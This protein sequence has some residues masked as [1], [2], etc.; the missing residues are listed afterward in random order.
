MKSRNTREA[1]ETTEQR[2]DRIA[3]RSACSLKKRDVRDATESEEQRVNRRAVKASGQAKLRATRDAAESTEQRADRLAEEKHKRDKNETDEQHTA[4]LA[5]RR[6]NDRKRKAEQTDE[7]RDA[8]R[9]RNNERHHI[10][11]RDNPVYKLTI[12]LRDRLHG[13]MKTQ[14]FKKTA[15]TEELLGCTWAQALEHLHNN[16][17]GLKLTD[18]GIHVDHIKPFNAFKHLDTA[19]EQKLVNNW[20]NL[21][22]LPAEENLEKHSKFDYATW[23]VSDAGIRFLA[24]ELELRAAEDDG[25]AV[26]YDGSS[27]DEFDEEFSEDEFDEEFSEDEE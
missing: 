23:S 15:K 4:R 5:R 26:D 17:R 22:L 14:G 8:R 21:Q 27:D 1:N 10:N 12:R 9:A 2:T 11:L 16:P 3:K 13:C 18:E 7:Q 25:D 20:R 6:E 24:F 19:K